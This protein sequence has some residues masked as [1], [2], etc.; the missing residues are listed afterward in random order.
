MTW[1]NKDTAL[2]LQGAGSLA[3]AWGQYESNKKRNKILQQQLDYAKEQD[4]LALAKQNKA[5]DNLDSAFSYSDLNPNKKKKKD[6]L[7]V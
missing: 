5:Q 2:A 3:S 4:A 7:N 1:D 6:P